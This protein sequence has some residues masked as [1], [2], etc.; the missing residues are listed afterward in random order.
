[1]NSKLH[2][3]PVEIIISYFGHRSVL[4][5]HGKIK[6]ECRNLKSTLKE[7]DSRINSDHRIKSES[8]PIF[9]L[10][11][12]WRTGSTL[13]QRLICSDQSTLIWGEPYGDSGL[14][15]F[16]AEPLRRINTNWP[17]DS[18]FIKD[19]QDV[20]AL[21]G[22]WI[23]NLNPPLDDLYQ[24][25]L[26]F[27]EQLFAN[28]AK[29]RGASNW[30]IKEV[31]LDGDLAYYLRWL[32]PKSKII[33]LV[34]DPQCAFKSYARFKKWYH[35]R[36]SKPAFT[37][38]QFAE[39]WNKLANSFILSKEEI[40]ALLVRY[41]DLADKNKGTIDQLETYLEK[42]IDRSVLDEKITIAKESLGGY[43]VVFG[44]MSQLKRIT[45]ETRL[46]LGY[47]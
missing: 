7:I 6:E 28:P 2:K 41:E 18:Y 20:T 5:K 30:G 11:A 4:K 27:F 33:Y 40:G 34:R 12:G 15:E 26:A 29:A 42:P 45:K 16:I 19:G 44:E 23:A 36:P 10:A 46:K 32:Y 14:L 1:M 35:L 13:L 24:S 17:P 43:R 31:R 47:N 25:H 39:H 22:E 3:I 38:R 8:S 37:V 9:L 21:S